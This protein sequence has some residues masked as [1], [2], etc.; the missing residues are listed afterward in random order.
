MKVTLGT[1]LAYRPSF[2]ARLGE[3]SRSR[4]VVELRAK[5]LSTTV[6][7]S[8]WKR[9]QGC[10]ILTRRRRTVNAPVLHSTVARLVQPLFSERLLLDPRGN[11]EHRRE[12][13]TIVNPRYSQAQIVISC[14]ANCLFVPCFSH[15][16]QCNAIHHAVSIFVYLMYYH[17]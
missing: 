5:T 9:A 1:W 8:L 10:A 6:Q 7:Q 17:S 16:C 15:F 2:V 3:S 14:V 12:N 11:V 4:L 13:E